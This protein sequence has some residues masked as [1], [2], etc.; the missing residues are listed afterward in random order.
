[1][2][3][4]YFHAVRSVTKTYWDN[5]YEWCTVNA[6]TELKSQLHMP[7]RL[8]ICISI[9]G[10]EQSVYKLQQLWQAHLEEMEFTTLQY[11][12]QLSIIQGWTTQFAD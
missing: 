5:V 11:Y 6:V 8:Y 4:A 12:G 7:L 1:M 10:C 3:L 2:L 9:I